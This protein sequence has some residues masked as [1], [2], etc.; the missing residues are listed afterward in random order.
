MGVQTGFASPDRNRG[1][2]SYSGIGDD[3]HATADLPVRRRK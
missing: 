2:A 1:I 3:A